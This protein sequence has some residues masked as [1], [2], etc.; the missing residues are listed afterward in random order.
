MKSFFSFNSEK[1]N[2]E[3]EIIDLYNHMTLEKK[4]WIKE[5]FFLKFGKNE[6][7]FEK[8]YNNYLKIKPFKINENI[9]ETDSGTYYGE[10]VQYIVLQATTHSLISAFKDMKI[11]LTDPNVVRDIKN[12]NIGTP[13]RIAKMWV[14][15]STSDDT[16]LMSG[17]WIYKPRIAVFPN[18]SK[19][20]FPITKRVDLIAVCSHHSAPFS[21]MFREDSYAV[22]SYIP[23][24]LVLGISKLQRMMDWL[25]RRGWLQEDLARETYNEISK[26]ANSKS[27][28][29]KFHNIVHNCEYL[30]GAQSHDG[31]FT[32]EHYGGKFRAKELRDQVDSKH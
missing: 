22:I 32:T 25:G 23:E 24:D 20:Q 8:H 12:K 29:V 27:V 16:E 2:D 17:R 3:T 30:R 15:A 5:A 14:G 28:Y 18:D 1:K 7:E 21:S 11:D 31:A 13:G 10:E 26:I 6:K 19:E 4:E 9:F